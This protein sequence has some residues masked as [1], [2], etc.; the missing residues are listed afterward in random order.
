MPKETSQQ[1]QNLQ[2]SVSSQ[3]AL[4]AEPR[5]GCTT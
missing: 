1:Q 3:S 2:S 5:C 4:Y